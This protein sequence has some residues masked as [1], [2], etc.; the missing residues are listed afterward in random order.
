LAT[1]PDAR[2]GD[3]LQLLSA[4]RNGALLVCENTHLVGIFTERDALKLMAS[5]ADL[6]LPIRDVMTTDPVTVSRE[7]TVADAIEKMSAGGYR[8]LPIVGADGEPSG[9]IAVRGIMHYLVEH[10]PG[11]IYNLPPD[12]NETQ[13]HREGA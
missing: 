10:F 13:T 1:T 9:V 6:S 4:Q 5:G 3:L 2:V 11:T 8:H 7:A 12:P